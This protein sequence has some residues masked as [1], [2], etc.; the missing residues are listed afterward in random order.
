MAK[1]SQST[2][3]ALPDLELPDAT[4]SHTYIPF[5]SFSLWINFNVYFSVAG[6]NMEEQWSTKTDKQIRKINSN[7]NKSYEPNETLFAVGWL[8]LQITTLATS[9]TVVAISRQA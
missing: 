8:R 6:M 4:I 5:Q 1:H 2:D 3:F 7:Q 9:M